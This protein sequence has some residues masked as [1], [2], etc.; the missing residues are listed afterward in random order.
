[1]IRVKRNLYKTG[2]GEKLHEAKDKERFERAVELAAE[3][4][5]QRESKDFD[6]EKAIEL[7]T[8]FRKD[9]ITTP[10]GTPDKEIERLK[11]EMEINQEAIEYAIKVIREN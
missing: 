9:A 6:K 4:W 1:M 7:L 10:E 5:N 11:R 8:E 2:I 3:A